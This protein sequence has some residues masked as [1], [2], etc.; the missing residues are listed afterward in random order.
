M[1]HYLKS[2]YCEHEPTKCARYI[3]REALGK[4]QVPLDLFPDE[5]E[6]AAKMIAIR[7]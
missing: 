5:A 2:A 7:G 6:K 4:D 3:V 1:A